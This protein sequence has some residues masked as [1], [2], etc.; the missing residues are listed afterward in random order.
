LRQGDALDVL[1][2]QGL[3]QAAGPQEEAA[4]LIRVEVTKWAKLIKATGIKPL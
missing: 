4:S 3:E 2:K 1:E